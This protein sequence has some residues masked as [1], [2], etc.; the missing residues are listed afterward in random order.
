MGDLEMWVECPMY[1]YD[2]LDFL[3]RICYQRSRAYFS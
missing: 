3:D 1:S 2:L